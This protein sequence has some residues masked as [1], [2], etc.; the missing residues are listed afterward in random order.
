MPDD[1]PIQHHVDATDHET[2]I[3]N[4]VEDQNGRSR[5]RQRLSNKDKERKTACSS[6][7]AFVNRK[8][9]E[10]PA[11]NMKSLKDH[12][13][14]GK[15]KLKCTDFTEDERKEIF[16]AY[17]NMG[18]NF[19]AKKNFLLT[20][21][22][23]SNVQRRQ[24]KTS[25]KKTKSYQYFLMKSGK[26]EPVCREFF[27]KTLSISYKPII[28]AHQKKNEST[29]VYND[30]DQR[31][32]F[33]PANKLPDSVLISIKAHIDSFPRVDSH[34]CRKKSKRQYLN[35]KLNVTKMYEL[36][37]DK[38]PDV[39][40]SMQKYQEIFATQYNLSFFKPRKDQ[41]G[42]CSVYSN[43]KESDPEKENLAKKYAD[44]IERKEHCRNAM[45]RDL[46][47]AKEDQSMIV[48]TFDLQSVLQVPES[49]ESAFYYKR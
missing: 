6:G 9:K 1:P 39:K 42:Q 24:V 36:F 10:R 31:G 47:L 35:A 5:W 4:Q 29:N 41:C 12:V 2:L 18:D 34:Y 44:H 3:D 48:A 23:Q 17:W 30:E 25:D 15:T 33:A 38:N 11:K 46:D 8:G 32:K 27:C 43:L 26:M 19:K 40:V 28:K 14:K 7:K 20:H 13:H 37:K 45:K 21:T 49:A 16:E 22:K